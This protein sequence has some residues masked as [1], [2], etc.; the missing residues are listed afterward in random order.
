MNLNLAFDSL[1]QRVTELFAETKEEH[2]SAKIMVRTISGDYEL[3]RVVLDCNHSHVPRLI[4][5]TLRQNGRRHTAPWSDQV[6][7]YADFDVDKESVCP[8]FV[9]SH[10]KPISVSV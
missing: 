4:W 9:E 3:L 5:M 7:L 8:V 6:A 10:P 2:G 1:K